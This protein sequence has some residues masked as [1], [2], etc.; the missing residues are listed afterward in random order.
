MPPSPAILRPPGRELSRAVG[1][2]PAQ[3]GVDTGRHVAA[4]LGSIPGR[5][6]PCVRLPT[7]PS[8][9]R[10]PRPPAAATA[11]ALSSALLRVCD[12]L[13]SDYCA[14]RGCAPAPRA[15]PFSPHA[16]LSPRIVPP[17]R[18]ARPP[19]P[20]LT[21]APPCCSSSLA[22]RLQPAVADRCRAGEGGGQPGRDPR[23]GRAHP[24]VQ[25]H[26][27]QARRLVRIHAPRPPSARPRARARLLHAFLTLPRQR[28]GAAS[29]RR[30]SW[31]S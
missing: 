3:P 17:D 16:R 5:G 13:E 7:P 27:P 31:S 2:R 9:L 1:D 19:R 21:P 11:P 24:G 25:G 28:T 10:D 29:R 12:G 14:P 20:L 15:A 8:R 6:V 22:V 4:P 26:Q 23:G 30:R 18:W